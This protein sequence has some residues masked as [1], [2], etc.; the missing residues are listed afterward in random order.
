MC[1]SQIHK[2]YFFDVVIF[3]CKAAVAAGDKVPVLVNGHSPT[4]DPNIGSIEPSCYTVLLSNVPHRHLLLQESVV[5][6]ALC[7]TVLGR[8]GLFHNW[9]SYCKPCGREGAMNLW[10]EKDQLMS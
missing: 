9:K 2:G 1:S 3:P 10:D 4:L 5:D 7:D 6:R 8:Q